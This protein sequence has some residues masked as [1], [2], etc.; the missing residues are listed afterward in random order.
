M[1]C[2]PLVYG[3][4]KKSEL[5]IARDRFG[6]KP[7]YWAIHN[8]SFFF[9]SELKTFR[10][11]PNLE[12]RVKKSS[13]FSLL[14]YSC[15]P[16]PETIFENI[17]KVE[18]GKFVVYD[19]NLKLIKDEFWNSNSLIKNRKIVSNDLNTCSDLIESELEKTVNSTMVSDVPIG[20]FLSGGIDSSLITALMTKFSTT[21]VQSYSIGF[22]NKEFNEA[23]YAK[24][25]AEYLQTNHNE[26]YVS[27]KELLDVIPLLPKIYS[28]PFADSSQIPTYLVSKLSSKKTKVILSGDGADELFGGYNR[29]Y[30]AEKIEYSKR[31]IPNPV[32]I[33]LSQTLKYISEKKKNIQD[34]FLRKKIPQFNDKLKKLSQIILG[35]KD[36]IYENLISSSSKCDNLIRDFRPQIKE[37]NFKKSEL[38]FL[39]QCNFR[40]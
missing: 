39:K 5:I 11:I 19:K 36:F 23:N 15:I 10:I 30:F 34:L 37:L 31:W 29:Y 6:I 2:L 14:R 33:F 38:C 21:K 24:K 20:S 28:E 7:L 13:I 9:S 25:I 26:A 32:K 35:D 40:I 4:K 1:E 8:K 16:A 17:F 18:P 12:P 3:T 22:E 27:E